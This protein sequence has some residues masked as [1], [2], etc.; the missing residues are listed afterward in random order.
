LRPL[1]TLA[2]ALAA[3]YTG[4]TTWPRIEGGVEPEPPPGVGVRAA[5]CAGCHPAAAET[6][7]GSRHAV[8]AS[9]PTFRAAWEH[10]P[11]GWCLGCHAPEREG[12]RALIGR[13]AVPGGFRGPLAE[14]A[15][16]AWQEG[17]SCAVCHVQDGRILSNRASPAAHEA[18]PMEVR[19]DFGSPAFCGRCHEFPFQL[20]TPDRPFGYSDNP[21]QATVSEWRTSHA[22]DDGIT[23]VDCHMPD[24]SHAFPGPHTPGMVADAVEVSVRQRGDDWIATVRADPPH[25]IPSGDPFRRM[26]LRVCADVACAQVVDRATLRHAIRVDETSWHLDDDTT[27]SP[28]RPSRT[29]RLDARG[30]VGWQLWFMYGDRRFEPNLPPSERGMLVHAGPAPTPSASRAAPQHP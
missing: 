5:D 20:H 1:P 9:N 30:A 21:S 8:A 14:P 29:F 6:W 27:L 10:W 15:P 26:E 19:G 17:V 4:A 2:A 13:D 28:R 23:C 12:Q 18:H 24:G 7:A 22:A 16:G 11:N 3:A 25:G